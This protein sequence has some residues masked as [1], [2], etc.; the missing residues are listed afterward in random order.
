MN[1]FILHIGHGKCA[2]STLQSFL[3]HN[4]VLGLATPG[5]GVLRYVAVQSDGRVLHGEALTDYAATASH[6]YASSCSEFMSDTEVHNHAMEQIMRISGPGDT[7][8]ASCETWANT[9]FVTKEFAQR[10]ADLP[11]ELDIVLMTRPPVDWA[12]A[13]WWQWGVRSGEDLASSLARFQLVNFTSALD[14][15]RNLPNIGRAGV[16]DISQG[17]VECFL[18]FAGAKV[19]GPIEVE[20]V[21]LASDYDLLRHLVRNKGFYQRGVAPSETEFRLN[22]LAKF[23]RKPLP[24]VVTRSAAREMI[25]RDRTKNEALLTLIEADAPP[26]AEEVRRKYIDETAYSHLPDDWPLSDFDS[27]YSD[28]FVFNLINTVLSLGEQIDLSNKFTRS[29]KNFDP[30]VYLTIHP[31]VR[32]RGT[33]PFEHFMRHGARE[34]RRLR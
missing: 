32:A 33:N 1:R 6:R 16:F 25:L 17:P 13:A 29:L 34:G 12:N 24:F 4:P 8:V 19:S 7:V 22:F 5:G 31:D 30:N 2:S 28:Q 27:D 9:G 26:L 21:N 10:V 11:T 20:S 23:E 18:N 15:W 14:Q 3:S